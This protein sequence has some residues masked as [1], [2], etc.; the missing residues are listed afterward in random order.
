MKTIHDG[1]TAGFRGSGDRAV[2]LMAA[3]VAMVVN[4]F[5]LK[6]AT[7]EAAKCGFHWLKNT[8]RHGP[9]D[10]QTHVCDVCDTFKIQ[11]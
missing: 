3:V 2:L 9:K 5:I 11:F 8:K 10:R 6:A 1:M 4:A 7:I